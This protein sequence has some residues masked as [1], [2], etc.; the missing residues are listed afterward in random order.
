MGHH[1]SSCLTTDQHPH[2]RLAALLAP[3]PP[4]GTQPQQNHQTSR[5]K[6]IYHSCFSRLNHQSSQVTKRFRV[7]RCTCSMSDN[8]L[9]IHLHVQTDLPPYSDSARWV[10]SDQ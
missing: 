9:Y 6:W 4:P 5:K 7:E 3:P 10:C 8:P 2:Y 1:Q